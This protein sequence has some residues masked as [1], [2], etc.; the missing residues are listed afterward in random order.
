MSRE[1][2]FTIAR[3]DGR[4]N[5]QVILDLVRDG[6]PGRV[7]SYIELGAALADGSDHSY[8]VASVQG[9][10]RQAK[11]RLSQEQQRVLRNVS[12]VGYKLAHANEHATLALDKNRRADVQLRRGLDI[13]R[14]V[15]FE[16][17]DPVHR[18]AHEGQLMVQA[19]L[20]QNQQALW[21]RQHNVEKALSKLTERVDAIQS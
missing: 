9:I 20:Y 3:A 17:M 15:R 19:A 7:Y 1:G 21:K 2:R 14:H 12:G 16:E 4:S 11:G 18:Q 6:E 5:Q 13:L 8:A 10:V